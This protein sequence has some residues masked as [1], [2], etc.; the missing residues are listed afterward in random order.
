MKEKRFQEKRKQERET[1][2]TTGQAFK[3]AKLAL[4]DISDEDFFEEMIDEYDHTSI[5]DKM[6]SGEN[7]KAN[8]GFILRGESS[9]S[10]GAL[11]TINMKNASCQTATAHLEYSTLLEVSSSGCQILE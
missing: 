3:P 1:T 5:E 11:V 9:L 4:G 2:A 8:E 10:T 6:E 7:D